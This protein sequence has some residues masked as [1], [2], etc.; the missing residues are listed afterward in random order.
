M[1]LNSIS[2][3][4]WAI[5]YLIRY[6]F[7]KEW[8]YFKVFLFSSFYKSNHFLLFFIKTFITISTEF[9]LKTKITKSN[10]KII[11]LKAFWCDFK[12]NRNLCAIR[13][14][15]VGH[16]P[17]DRSHLC[18]SLQWSSCYAFV[19]FLSDH[20][21]WLWPS[22]DWHP[23]CFWRHTHRLLRQKLMKQLYSNN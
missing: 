20:W 23:P 14:F 7:C 9:Y 13:W 15:L 3:R 6:D 1:D 5:V 17:E 16:R 18:R 10:E 21:L 19:L 11:C 2:L 22:V 8:S 12:E 4:N